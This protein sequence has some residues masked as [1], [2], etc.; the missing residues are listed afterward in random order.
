MLEDTVGIPRGLEGTTARALETA[1]S[2]PKQD[3]V[4]LAAKV[5]TLTRNLGIVATMSTTF[6]HPY[7]L[8]RLASTMDS[9][10]SGRFGWN[11]VTSAKDEAAQNFGMDQM[12]DREVRYEMAEEFVECVNALCDSWEPG[13]IVRDRKKG[14]YIDS[15]KVHDVDFNGKYFKSRGPLTCVRSPQGRPIYLQAGGSPAGRAFAAK[16]ADAV[17]AWATGIEGMKEYRADIRAQAEAA[18]RDP[19]AVKVMFLFSPILGETEAEARAKIKP[20]PDEEIP[21]RLRALS[22]NFY[23]DFTTMDLDKPVPYFVTR[24]EQGSLAAFA[25]WG[26]GK[27]LRECMQ[28]H[29]GGGASSFEAVGTPDQVADIM[30]AAME[31]VGGDGFLIPGDG[32]QLTRHRINEICDGLVPAL[33]A[34]GLTRTTYSHE[35]LRDNLLAF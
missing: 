19:D 24:G 28:A 15:S 18:G 32:G 11:I 12:P 27:T 34:R 13:A 4:P 26:T 6:Y 2:C 23:A 30:A 35:L 29:S 5:G 9:M 20:L 3:P 1:D 14:I 22:S 21:A 10:L 16:H 17:I 33:Q 25:Q 7:A 31:E 8:A